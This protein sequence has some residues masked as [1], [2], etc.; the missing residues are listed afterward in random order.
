MAQGQLPQSYQ[1]KLSVTITTI[2]TREELLE[3]HQKQQTAPKQQ[4]MMIIIISIAQILLIISPVLPIPT[5]TSLT[6][7]LPT[8]LPTTS[9]PSTSNPTIHTPTTLQ[10]FL[11]VTT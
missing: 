6:P 11:L 3:T 4:S 9:I 10:L 1:I 5:T 7:S 2:K 8:S